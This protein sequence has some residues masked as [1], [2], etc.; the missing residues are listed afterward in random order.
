MLSRLFKHGARL[1]RSVF[2]LSALHALALIAACG[3][4][5]FTAATSNGGGAGSGAAGDTSSAGGGDTAGGG[6]AGSSDEGGGSGKPSGGS[7]GSGGTNSAGAGTG[8]KPATTCVS[9]PA[10]NYCQDGTTKCRTCADFSRLEF[11][12]PQKLATLSQVNGSIERFPRSANTGANTAA[13]FYTVGDVGKERIWYSAAPTSGVGAAVSSPTA[14][15]SGPVLAPGFGE[16]N[17]YFDRVE[18]ATNK[19][20]IMTADWLAGSVSNAA[21]AGSPVNVT[22]SDD[23]SIAVAPNAGHAYW[24]ST[25]N[26]LMNPE[27][28]WES[29]NGSAPPPPGPLPLTI[30]VG[31][32]TGCARRGDDATPWVNLDGTLLLFRAVSM[33]DTCAENDSGAYDLFAAPLAKDGTPAAPAIPLSSLNNTGGKSNESD[34]SFSQD[35]CTMYFASDS[36]TGDYDLYRAARN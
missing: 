11:A 2:G 10:N 20:K 18:L 31:A 36:G 17:F 24:M 14:V 7:G 9:C 25:R 1:P 13:L 33:D 3:G 26:N 4:Q 12:A 6:D 21:L 27:L 34:P 28:V 32:N 16:H 23:Y 29:I 19:R 8:G 35:F 22:G 5:E 30:K 15:D